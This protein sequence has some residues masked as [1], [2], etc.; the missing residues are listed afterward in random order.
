[1]KSE[2]MKNKHII[3]SAEPIVNEMLSVWQLI[4]VAGRDDPVCRILAKVCGIDYLLCSKTAVHGVTICVQHGKNDR[5]FIVSKDSIGNDEGSLRPYYAMQ[6]YVD[7]GKLSGLGVVKTEDLAD[8]IDEG[9]AFEKEEGQAKFYVCNWD[10][11]RLAGYEV[12]EYDEQPA[13]EGKKAYHGAKA[14]LDDA[15]QDTPCACGTYDLHD[16]YRICDEVSSVFGVRE[17]VTI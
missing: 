14:T 7:D 6:V 10:D 1:M 3:K 8:F 17:Q 4:P 5:T 9:F 11:L 15:E 12:K 16:I 13:T 2:A